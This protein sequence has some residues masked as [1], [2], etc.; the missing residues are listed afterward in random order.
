MTDG[1]KYKDT[2]GRE[3]HVET[4]LEIKEVEQYGDP[5]TLIMEAD[6]THYALT[7]FKVKKTHNRYIGDAV[8]PQILI[9]GGVGRSAYCL[10]VKGYLDADYLA[11]KIKGSRCDAYNIIHMLNE[12]GYRLPR[13]APLEI[14]E[15]PK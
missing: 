5:Q 8:S 11:S 3:H 2:E 4:P 10:S 15:T 13:E 9:T 14:V 6:G 1:Y 7:V 12:A